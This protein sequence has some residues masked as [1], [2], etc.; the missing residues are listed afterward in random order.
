MTAIYLLLILFACSWLW[1]H[2]SPYLAIGVILVIIPLMWDK[3][4]EFFN[5]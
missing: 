5:F 4:T 3:I 2:I 1:N